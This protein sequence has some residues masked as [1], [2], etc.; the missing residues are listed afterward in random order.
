MTTPA[1]LRLALEPLIPTRTSGHRTW[2]EYGF[3][4]RLP[5]GPLV[6]RGD[7]LLAAYAARILSVVID[8][9]DDEQLQDDAFEP[10]SLVRLVLESADEPQLGVW[11]DDGLH[12]AGCLSD[13]SALIAAAAMEYGL[14]QS[15]LIL[16]EDRT[17]E[18]GRREGLDL[19]VFHDA[20]VQVDTAAVAGGFLRPERQVRPR[21]VLVA[22]GTD[23]VRWWDPAAT[24]GPIAADDLPMSADLTRAMQRLRAGYADLQQEDGDERRGL[25]R[26]EA[27]LDR[28]TLDEQAAALWRRARA[29]L[30]RRYAIGFLGTGMERPVW[31]PEELE[32]EYESE[33]PF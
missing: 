15:A 19:L 14:A 9:D 21:L 29:E 12:R 11:D 27:A 20:F 6:D 1:P 3:Q 5:D 28:H 13:R 31:S 33:I 2:L 23:D 25:E 18:D 7:P 8:E 32:D 4:L 22:D 24:A 17:P 30:G 26:F 10:G 16:T